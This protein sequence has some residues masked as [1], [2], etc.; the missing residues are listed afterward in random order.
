[1]TR[2]LVIEDEWTIRL[3]IAVN[4][5]L[6]GY[7][8]VEAED[9]A[10]AL[11]ILQNTDVDLVVTDLLMP[12]VSGMELIAWLKRERAHLPVVAVSA[13]ETDLSE[14]APVVAD[15]VLKKPFAINE[16]LQFI[17]TILENRAQ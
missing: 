12:N 11:E 1:M 17:R 15:A 7:E 14:I 4:L 3:F 2:I 16:L 9:G 5:K 13:A 6:R 8:V 10:E